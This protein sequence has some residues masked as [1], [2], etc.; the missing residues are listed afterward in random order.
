MDRRNAA[1]KVRKCLALAESSEPHEAAAALRQA[2]ALMRRH[3]LTDADVEQARVR[4]DR[5]EGRCASRPPRWLVL[6]TNTVGGAF[7]AIPVHGDGAVRF[8][9]IGERASLASYAFD[10]LLRQLRRARRAH[11]KTLRRCKP[12]NRRR[13]ADLFCESWTHAV[14]R[15][16]T[17]FSMASADR[18]LIESWLAAN[19]PVRTRTSKG[20]GSLSD[21]D[22]RSIAA[23]G[24]A[25]AEAALLHPVAGGAVRPRLLAAK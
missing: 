9:S 1:E 23:G 18:A 13:R 22:W 8:V 7:G 21:R 4:S 2:Q 20:A 15:K 24:A 6:L 12:A 3:G 10:V 19:L 11:L 25:G 14:R 17:D 5:S 16:V